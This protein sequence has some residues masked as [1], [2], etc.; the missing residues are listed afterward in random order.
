MESPFEHKS[1]YESPSLLCDSLYGVYFLFFF[2]QWKNNV[3]MGLKN[4]EFNEHVP[5][6]TMV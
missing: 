2:L 5:N 4:Y 3:K 1:P 6:L